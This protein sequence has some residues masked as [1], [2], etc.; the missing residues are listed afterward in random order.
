MIN[1]RHE[2]CMM[3]MMMMMNDTTLT[4]MQ[5]DR[6]QDNHTSVKTCLISCIL[7]HSVCNP[8]ITCQA[9]PHSHPQP[10][11]TSENCSFYYILHIRVRSGGGTGWRRKVG[12]GQ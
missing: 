4:K 6:P 11:S 1:S 5:G 8:C 12:S 2:A 9:H 7:H 10:R 3:M